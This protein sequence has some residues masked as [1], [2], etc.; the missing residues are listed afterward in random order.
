MDTRLEDAFRTADEYHK[1]V[2]ANQE[3]FPEN[4]LMNAAI[5]AWNAE[6]AVRRNLH[7]K[8]QLAIALLKAMKQE[9]EYAIYYAECYNKYSCNCENIYCRKLGGVIGVGLDVVSISLVISGAGALPGAVTTG[10]SIANNVIYG[11]V[12]DKVKSPVLSSVLNA[13]SYYA[14]TKAI[15][16]KAPVAGPAIGLTLTTIDIVLTAGDTFMPGK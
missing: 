6:V 4:E 3:H 15:V 9:K 14:T 2:L 11:I 12:C 10:L 7:E 13:G 8:A 5:K 1:M 16:S